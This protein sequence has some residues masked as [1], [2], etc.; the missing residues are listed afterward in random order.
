MHRPSFTIDNWCATR[1]LSRSMFYKLKS[2]R[3]APKTHYVGN[4][5]LISP[6]AD[7]EWL[8][9]REAEAQQRDSAEASHV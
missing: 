5:P 2:E 3:K 7:A 6:E 9:E 1:G 4:K 8:R